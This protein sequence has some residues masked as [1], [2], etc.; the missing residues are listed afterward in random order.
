MKLS[1]FV[2]FAAAVA[3]ALTL[4]ACH[5]ASLPNIGNTRSATAYRSSGVAVPPA[6]ETILSRRHAHVS[7]I[8]TAGWLS[9]SASLGK[10]LMY[11]ATAG[12]AVYIYSTVGQAQQPI[13]VIT[14]G[15]SSPEGLAV[16]AVGN[17]YVANSGNNTVTVYPPGQT[18]PS[19]TYSNGVSNPFGVAVGGD[20]RVY[21]ANENTSNCYGS[22]TEYPKG[23][24]N[25]DRTLTLSGRYAFDAALDTAGNLYV[26][27][28]DLTSYA[29]SVYKYAPGSTHGTNLDL[30]LPKLVFPAFTLAF[31]NAGNL[32]LAVENGNNTLP[33]KYIAVFPPGSRNPSQKIE[34]GSLL[35]IV[36]GIAFPRRSSEVY[37]VTNANFYDW[38]KLTYPQT[39]PRDVDVVAPTTGLALSPDV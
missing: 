19:T 11:V 1:T 24:L 10:N 17:L 15:V 13:G 22:V 3:L 7:Q 26:S 34:G 2:L 33:P 27:W 16:D 23:S 36:D 31:D 35:D 5:A 20:G 30:M 12:G 28:Y 14:S 32:V 25:P 29:I 4:V 8:H 37:Y 9:E 18:S 21:I 39:L 38:M 6:L